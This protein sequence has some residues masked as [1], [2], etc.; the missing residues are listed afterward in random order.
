MSSVGETADVCT[1]LS[2]R[3][4]DRPFLAQAL[5]PSTASSASSGSR[6]LHSGPQL[7]SRLPHSEPSVPE[8]LE[9]ESSFIG[10][11]KSWSGSLQIIAQQRRE[12]L[13]EGWTD[14]QVV[15]SFC[16]FNVFPLTHINRYSLG[17]CSM[18]ALG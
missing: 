12:F 14:I 8:L 18:P 15:V 9:R 3:L 17:I 6:L 2:C 7:C 4:P 5:S 13:P 10:E 16:I 1:Q 11:V